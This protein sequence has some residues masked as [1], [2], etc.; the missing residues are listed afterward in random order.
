V[1]ACAH[2][3]CADDNIRRQFR[4]LRGRQRFPCKPQ[5]LHPLLAALRC[6][7]FPTILAL[8]ARHAHAVA[9]QVL[10]QVCERVAVA[11]SGEQARGRGARERDGGAARAGAQLQH[12]RAHKGGG[13]CERS[14]SQ[15]KARFPSGAAGASLEE[16]ARAAQREGA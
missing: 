14:F 1:R 4:S 2:E 13:V 5:Q 10:P 9:A 12:A 11:V 15:G 6:L 16:I 8:L 3:V 7:I